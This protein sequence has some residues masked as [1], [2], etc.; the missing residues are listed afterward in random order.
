VN[1]IEFKKYV[2]V[3]L[4]VVLVVLSFYIVQPFLLAIFLGAILAYAFYPFYKRGQKR[5]K[6]KTVMALIVCLIILILIIIPSIFFVKTLIQESY[7]LYVLGKQ[8]IAVGLFEDCGNS[9]CNLIESLSENPQ[10]KYR[11]QESLRII[12]NWI[13][14]KGSDFLISI[15]QI[16]LNLFVMFFTLFYFLRDGA[17]FAKKMSVYLSMKKKR[18]AVMIGRLKEIIHAI[19]YGYVLI[20][21][22]QG[23][24]GALGFYIFGV[25]SPLFWGMVMAFLALIPYLGTGFVWVPA[26]LI[27]FLDGVFQNSN[28][29]IYKGIGLFFYGLIIVGSLDNLI[30]PKIIGDKAKIHPALI[31]LGIFGGI[32]LMG[33]IGVVA[34]PLILSLTAIVIETYLAHRKIS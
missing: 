3:L 14:K 23:A 29:L 24:L 28:V 6:S 26:A 21:L 22:M 11:F 27:I 30:R 18:Y 33:P 4:F 1:K 12:T 16:L 9:I 2:P 32:F 31:M 10:V 13:I 5:L 15:P 25:S 7:S 17:A 34:G 20:A 19:I 8:K